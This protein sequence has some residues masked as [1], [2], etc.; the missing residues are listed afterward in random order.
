MSQDLAIVE[1]KNWLAETYKPAEITT[2]RRYV[3]KPGG[4]GPAPSDADIMFFAMYCKANNID[5]LQKQAHLIMTQR[6]PEVAMGID[7]LR[8]R[9]AANPAYAGQELPVFREGEDGLECVMVVYKMVHGQRCAFP[10]V[11]WMKESRGTSP[12]WQQRPRGMLEKAA[13]AKAL[14]KA[15]PKEC[16]AFYA[17]EELEGH[18]GGAPAS[19]RGVA[20]VQDINARLRQPQPVPSA[21][22]IDA[23]YQ[24][25]ADA[26]SDA[27]SSDVDDAGGETEAAFKERLQRMVA[28][29]DRLGNVTVDQLFTRIRSIPGREGI[30]TFDDIREE[31]IDTLRE[32][33]RELTNKGE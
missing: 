30:K 29:F 2:L 26:A 11:A 31:D 12:N 21:H 33:Y 3:C 13:E 10:A 17:A 5:P 4:K 8:G 15:F 27:G 24:D 19:S 22:T 25:D 28:A 32:L 23:E 20:N 16:G 9:A 1:A 6:G 14:R 7:G 18:E